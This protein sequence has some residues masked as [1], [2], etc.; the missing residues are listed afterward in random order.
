MAEHGAEG[1]VVGVEY[2]GHDQMVTVRLRS[3]T[4]LRIRLLAAPRVDLGQKVGVQVNGDVF[5]FPA[6][7]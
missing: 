2:F 6:R 1:E 7:S 5:A 4:R 3:G